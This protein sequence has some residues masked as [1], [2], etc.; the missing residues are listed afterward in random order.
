M[1]QSVDCLNFS[2][3][4]CKKNPSL[5][6]IIRLI[7]VKPKENQKLLQS[8]TKIFSPFLIFGLLFQ[9]GF[10]LCQQ[11]L[12]PSPQTS[13]A[14]FFKK[15]AVQKKFP[16]T[17]ILAQKTSTI[18]SSSAENPSSQKLSSGKSSPSTAQKQAESIEH[19]QF[20]RKADGV[21]TYKHPDHSHIIGTFQQNKTDKKYK[22]KKLGSKK[23]FNQIVSDK[24][25]ML[26]YI[27][28]SDWKVKEHYWKKRKKYYELGMRGSY[29][30]KDSKEVFFYE[31][32]FYY[33]E[34]VQQ[35]LIISPNEEFL[36]T[37]TALRFFARAR[38][39]LADKG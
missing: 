36:K 31:R 32:H 7:S 27:N 29:L 33:P 4:H 2:N 20:I 3:H 19:W 9:T 38:N 16:K 1:Y 23:I 34:N 6:S 37:K 25:N 15:T 8:F 22:W 18:Q 17:F 12:Q 10:A 13:L 11:S 21:S 24:K 5:S 14:R 39:I 28:I 30:N 35:M 26:S